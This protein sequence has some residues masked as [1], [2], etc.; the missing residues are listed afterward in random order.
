MNIIFCSQCACPM[1]EHE[2]LPEWRKC[3]TCGW[4]EKKDDVFLEKERNIKQNQRV[5]YDNKSKRH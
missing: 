3:N 4:C 5:K 2:T 1:Y